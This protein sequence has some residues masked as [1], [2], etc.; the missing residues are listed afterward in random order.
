M[1]RTKFLL[2]VICGLATLVVGGQI[3][4]W[5]LGKLVIVR[6]TYDSKAAVLK[7]AQLRFVDKLLPNDASNIRVSVNTYRQRGSLTFH[8]RP[9]DGEVASEMGLA[10]AEELTTMLQ[11][12]QGKILKISPESHVIYLRDST[13]YAIDRE[14]GVV[15]LSIG[16]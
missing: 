15:T 16:G 9:I 7:N 12:P 8:A 14:S 1:N 3:I 4:S 11:T 2:A 13:I 5:G 10:R 6:Q